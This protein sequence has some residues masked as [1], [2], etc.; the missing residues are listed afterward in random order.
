[1]ISTITSKGQVTIPAEV[2]RAV[3]LGAGTRVEF[4]VNSRRRIELVPRQADIRA[5]RGAVPMPRLAVSVGS[6]NTVVADAWAGVASIP[7]G[8]QRP[9]AQSTYRVSVEPPITTSR[10]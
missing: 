2:R 1:M 7:A 6:M 10:K 4:I 8:A 5:L 9:Q 3:G